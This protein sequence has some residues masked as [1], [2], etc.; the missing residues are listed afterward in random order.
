MGGD[1]FMEGCIFC[2]IINKEIPSTIVYEDEK[3]IAFND[4]NPAAP[5]HVLVI[6]KQHISCVAELESESVKLL[7]DIF[8][9]INKIADKLGVKDS[10]FRVITNNGKD[11][12]QV[13]HHLHFHLLGGRVLGSLG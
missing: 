12:G 9:A 8:I 4:I 2:K 5:V 1:E 11:S 6:P 7:P 13:V 10:G 3:V